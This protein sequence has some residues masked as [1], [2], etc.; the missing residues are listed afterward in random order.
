[1]SKP[2]CYRLPSMLRK[3]PVLAC[4][5]QHFYTWNKTTQ[6]I[7]RCAKFFHLIVDF[8]NNW[9]FSVCNKYLCLFGCNAALRN[10]VDLNPG[11]FSLNSRFYLCTVSFPCPRGPVQSVCCERPGFLSSEWITLPMFAKLGFIGH[12]TEPDNTTQRVHYRMYFYWSEREGLIS[13]LLEAYLC[14]WRPNKTKHVAITI[15]IT[16]VI[17][18]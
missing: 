9:S 12:S 3:I 8:C 2:G 6:L 5:L 17:Y 4:E 16:A 10:M 7:F 15:N 14:I 13:N 18:M 1:M 11:C